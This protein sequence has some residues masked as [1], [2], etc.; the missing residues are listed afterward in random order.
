MASLGKI[1]FLLGIVFLG[2]GGL[3]FL[4]A[5]F[6]LSFPFGRL[7]GDITIRTKGGI[8]FFPL[9]SMIIISIALSALFQ[10][11]RFFRK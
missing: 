9:T 5:H 2:F 11:L 10:A 6:N 8:F 1:F 4:F 3:C 7:P